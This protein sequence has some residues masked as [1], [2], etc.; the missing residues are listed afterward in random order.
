[1]IILNKT[2]EIEYPVA[3]EGEA[4]VSVRGLMNLVEVKIKERKRL[5]EDQLL[6]LLD[7]WATYRTYLTAGIE[8]IPYN[9]I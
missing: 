2:I 7:L 5:S 4:T 1:V 3:E 6:E 9:P 8:R